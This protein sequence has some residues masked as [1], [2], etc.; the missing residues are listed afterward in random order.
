LPAGNPRAEEKVHFDGRG[1]IARLSMGTEPVTKRGHATDFVLPE[2]RTVDGSSPRMQGWEP[3]NMPNSICV[4]IDVAK[5]S[6]EVA[7]G[8]EG[9]TCA[10]PNTDAG[11]QRLVKAL[12]A[13]PVTVVL[14][15]AT[16]GYE[17]AAAC[18]I[19]AAGIDVIVCNPWRARRFAQAS[20]YLAKT[21]RIDAIG[22]AQLADVLNRRPDRQHFLLSPPTEEQS[23]LQALCVRRSQLQQALIAE[24]NRLTLAHK[25]ARR[26]LKA[27][28]VFHEKQ[29]KAIEIEIGQHM[30]QHF[31]DLDKLLQSA[32]GIGP[33]TSS[34]MVAMLPEIGSLSR[35]EIAALV[36]VAPFN[37]DSGAYRGQRRIQGG[38]P[39][40]RAVLYMATLVAVR[41]NPAIR[42]F[43]QRLVAAGKAKKVA[44]VAAMRKLLTIVNAMVKTQRSWDESM[45]LA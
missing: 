5:D 3:K 36:G 17:R 7:L 15:E 8:V 6:L 34:M 27:A 20:G 1:R 45:H 29:I 38:R 30:K 25:A 42:A 10:F 9:P 16:G 37:R 31:V 2:A 41:H 11:H 40:L 4:G 18:A 12:M 14:L 28:I 26:S 33:T 19:H 22:L 44:L 21:D 39:A 23:V 32:K 35:R 13:H 43:Y 24:Q